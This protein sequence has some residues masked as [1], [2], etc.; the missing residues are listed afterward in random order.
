MAHTDM[1]RTDRSTALV[2]FRRD[3][4][5]DDHAALHHALSQHHKVY[6]TFVFDSDILGDKLA[7][8]QTRNPQVAFMVA[9][10][11]ALDAALRQYGSSLIPCQGRPQAEI[12]RLAGE[13]GAAV[14][15]AN[16]D[17]EPAA[18]QRD[19]DVSLALNAIGSGLR[20]FKDQVIFEYSDV[21]TQAGT[22]FG[23]F[24]PYKNAWLKRLKP[25]DLA[26]L[27]TQSKRHHL[28][29]PALAA[30]RPLPTLGQ[31]GFTATNPDA[32]KIPTGMHGAQQLFKDFST[33]IEHYGERRDFPAT[34]G[35]SYLSAHLR[36]GTLSIRQLWPLPTKPRGVVPKPG[37]RS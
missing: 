22:A 4:R 27:D 36:F 37:C 6:C 26:P 2:W 25:A 19:H 20:T 7:R 35:P 31:L 28:A 24:T 1:A 34:K 15:Y 12:P 14:V 9:T 29:A 32:L 10:L 3:L 17:Y 11:H 16:H 33:R 30:A 23:V 18:V 13:L 5:L 21:M 8:G